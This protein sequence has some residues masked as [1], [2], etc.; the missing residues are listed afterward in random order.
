MIKAVLNNTMYQANNRGKVNLSFPAEGQN[1]EI[2]FENNFQD[3][4]P[5]DLMTWCSKDSDETK[6]KDCYV[7][8]FMAYNMAHSVGDQF[9]RTYNLTFEID[10]RDE[11]QCFFTAKDT[12]C[13]IEG[14]SAIVSMSG[15]PSKRTFRTVVIYVKPASWLHGGVIAAFVLAS[16]IVVAVIAFVIFL[17]CIKPRQDKKDISQSS[18]QMEK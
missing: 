15:I 17:F 7:S 1:P 8:L 4:E 5:S 11:L 9:K 10:E 12:D 2:D 18:F 14:N 13:R 16:F 3:N 6:I